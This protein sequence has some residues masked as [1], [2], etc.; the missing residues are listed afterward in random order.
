L[1]K[2]KIWSLNRLLNCRLNVIGTHGATTFSIMTLTIMTLNIA[3]F[4]I[5]TLS[6]KGL[7]VTLS[8]NDTPHE[9][10]SE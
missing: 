7:I 5:T 1:P 8:M 4:G 10:H 9:W 3:T 6:K 2:D